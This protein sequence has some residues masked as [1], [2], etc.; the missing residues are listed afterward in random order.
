VFA[1]CE[2]LHSSEELLCHNGHLRNE[3]GVTITND[4]TY[5][6]AIRDGLL[7]LWPSTS[8]AS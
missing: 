8:N 7:N 4:T 5:A 1:G 6:T 3:A 2:R